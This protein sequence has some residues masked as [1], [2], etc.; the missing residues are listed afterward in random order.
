MIYFS[1]VN[2]YEFLLQFLEKII[3]WLILDIKWGTPADIITRKLFIEESGKLFCNRCL[4]SPS[5]K[6]E[7]PYLPLT[8]R[9]HSYWKTSWS[10]PWCYLL[11]TLLAVTA[12]YPAIETHLNQRKKER[13]RAL[14]ELGWFQHFRDSW[15]DLG[16]KS[17]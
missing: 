8:D 1:Q 9:T 13:E 16:Q 10:R 6:K 17:I 2:F 4:I 11:D 14:A 3:I 12:F 7:V 15:I 5:L